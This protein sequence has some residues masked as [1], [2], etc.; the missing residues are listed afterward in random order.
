MQVA[1]KGFTYGEYTGMTLSEEST[2][3]FTR[4]KKQ[5]E[6]M[7]HSV[8]LHSQAPLARG[9]S[10]LPSVLFTLF[11]RC[12]IYILHVNVLVFCT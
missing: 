12:S 7:F 9:S 10:A 3:P 1:D 5:L 2:P 8:R 11:T 4:G 6:R